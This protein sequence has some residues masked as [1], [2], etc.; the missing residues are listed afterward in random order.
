MN[1]TEDKTCQCA[2]P[3]LRVYSTRHT[4]DSKIQYLYCKRCDRLA[5]Q[6]RVESVLAQRVAALE[7]MILE[8]RKLF[9]A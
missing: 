6:K 9:R 5:G 8:L 2:E 1:A 7:A 3:E 4:S